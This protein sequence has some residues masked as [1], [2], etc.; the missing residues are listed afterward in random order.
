MQ[1]ELR[2]KLVLAA[3]VVA[4]VL[5]LAAEAR[6]RSPSSYG[7]G[8]PQSAFQKSHWLFRFGLAVGNADVADLHGAGVGGHFSLA[9][10]FGKLE[11]K[12]DYD[13]VNVT[14]GEPYVDH[15]RAGLMHRGGA[16]VRW[17]PIGLVIGKRLNTGFWVEGT[18]GREFFAWDK[19][20]TL[21]RNDVSIGV[22]VDFLG[23]F[24]D[25]GERAKLFG[26]GWSFRFLIADNPYADVNA[27]SVCGGP[28]DTP[29]PAPRYDL[30]FLFVLELQYGR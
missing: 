17:Q 16:G 11:L 8:S 26:F 24:A 21:T 30:S 4:A 23:N 28:C 5:A 13:L 15:P 20:G 9:R 19:G 1:P 10:S 3:A 25:W 2:R 7:D 6:A 29:T 12:A 22:G 27:V 18:V 14:E